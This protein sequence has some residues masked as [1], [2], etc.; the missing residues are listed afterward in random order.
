MNPSMKSR[1]MD[2]AS[3]N[4][5]YIS[6]T[7]QHP[8]EKVFEAFINPEWIRNW[9]GPVNVLTLNV[10][11]NLKVGGKYKFE[12]QKR[13]GELFQITGEYKDIVPNQL[14]VFSSAYQNLSS[15]PPESTVIIKFKTVD[16]GTEVSLVQE[17]EV[18][19]PDFKSRTKSW[20]LMLGR[21]DDL[22]A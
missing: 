10:D 15:P 2:G 6:R 17:F 16:K 14:L 21:I 3:K 1:A 13:N 4:K 11:V 22:L 18:A 5:V 9:W 7:F 8:V 19:P 12:M 20:E